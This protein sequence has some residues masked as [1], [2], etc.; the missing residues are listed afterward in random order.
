MRKF[1]TAAV[2]A[3]TAFTVALGGASIASAQE[4]DATQPAAAAELPGQG[5]KD[6]TLVEIGQAASSEGE[7][8]LSSKAGKVVD[9]YETV[10]GKD[11]L[12]LTTKDVAKEGEY[13]A[14]AQWA[15]MW[16]DATIAGVA[17]A[18][19]STIV[20]VYNFAVFNGLLPDFAANILGSLR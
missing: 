16:R 14:N 1:R 6:A 4:S 19:V 8:S 3:A 20:A 5:D 15:T 17:A 9:K 11:L 13:D 2:A 10:T 18:V 7:G 12:G